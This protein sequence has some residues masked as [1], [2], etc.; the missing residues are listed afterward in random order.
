[1]SG[2]A[3]KAL[4]INDIDKSPS[5][6]VL[7]KLSPETFLQVKSKLQ[8]VLAE[9]GDT[10]KWTAGGAGSWDPEHR[11][12][13]KGTHKIESGDVDVFID[14]ALVKRKLGLDPA[15]DDKA[16]RKEVYNRMSQKFPATQ[17]G[18]NVHIGYPAGY[19]VDVP[20]LGTKL[21]AYYQIDLMTMEH[22]HEIVKHHE[23]DYSVKDTPY[24]GVD[25]QLAMASLVNT[26]PGYPERTWQYHGFGGVL[27]PRDP[28]SG[29]LLPTGKPQ[30]R[31]I[32]TIAKIILNNP[33][34]SHDDLGN[35]ES[36]VAAVPGGLKS[37]RLAQFAADMA[38]KQKPATP[39]GTNEWFR[40]IMDMI[41]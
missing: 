22:A 2:N 29:V 3:L 41:T 25:Q 4:G 24:K 40:K 23:H 18:T 12:K 17:I 8:P 15:M 36:I 20:A 13:A 30:E 37:P 16:V 31:N 7:V 26:I 6:G 19:E 32:D 35:V 14:T 27:K 34:A 11:F 5:K 9:I 39:V 1:M 38:K 10:G 28:A 33:Q 21:P